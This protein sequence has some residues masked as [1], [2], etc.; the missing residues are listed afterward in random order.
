MA[1]GTIQFVLAKIDY[2]II[3]RIQVTQ[4]VPIP[5]WLAGGPKGG[6]SDS[7]FLSM[8]NDAVTAGA[9]GVVIGRNVW[10]RDNPKE[11]IEQL[12]DI[13]HAPNKEWPNGIDATK[14]TTA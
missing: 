4:S 7:D 8:V 6:G 3:S 2:L 11:I 14:G 12:C 1:N 10:M 5:V 13:F 9:T